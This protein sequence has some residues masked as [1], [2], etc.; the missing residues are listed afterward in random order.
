MIFCKLFPSL[1]QPSSQEPSTIRLACLHC[2]PQDSLFTRFALHKVLIPTALHEVLIP[3]ALHKNRS[4]QEPLATRLPT[5]FV[6]HE[7]LLSMGLSLRIACH[8]VGTLPS[9]LT[10]AR[11][12]KPSLYSLVSTARP[13]QPGLYSLLSRGPFRAS[14]STRLTLYETIT[15]WSAIIRS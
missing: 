3:T 8:E 14:L 10:T 13:P 12:L 4:L 9:W 7:V 15:P 2:Y 1:L 5:R 11:S 6:L